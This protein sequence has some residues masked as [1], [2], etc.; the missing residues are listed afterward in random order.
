MVKPY[1]WCELK[2]VVRWGNLVASA[3]PFSAECRIELEG[4][5]DMAAKAT[6]SASDRAFTAWA[7]DALKGC[8]GKAHKA[9]RSIDTA[10]DEVAA[11]YLEVLRE[12]GLKHD[13]ASEVEMADAEQEET[14]ERKKTLQKLQSS[15]RKSRAKSCEVMT[16]DYFVDEGIL[17]D[18]THEAHRT[19]HCQQ[20][21]TRCRMHAV[22]VVH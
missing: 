2:G 6:E 8:A 11:T 17:I 19:P 9:I 15:R 21:V 16:V 1:W 12:S 14:L 10:A 20:L 4:D 22:C 5:L 13:D 7:N 3:S 18:I